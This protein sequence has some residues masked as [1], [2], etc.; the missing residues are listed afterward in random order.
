MF[1]K[2]KNVEVDQPRL[3]VNWWLLDRSMHDVFGR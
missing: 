1:W 3:A 2:K